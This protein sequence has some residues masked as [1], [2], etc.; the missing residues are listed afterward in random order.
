ML[1]LGSFFLR[2]LKEQGLLVIRHVSG[3]QNDADILT[4]KVTAAVFEKHLPLYV[5][6]DEYMK[7]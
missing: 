4:K 6:R 2:E 1:M 3:D 7:S 5:G